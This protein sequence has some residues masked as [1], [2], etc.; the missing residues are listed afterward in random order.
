[1][2]PEASDRILDLKRKRELIMIDPILRILSK[3]HQGNGM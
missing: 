2:P 1:M 3:V